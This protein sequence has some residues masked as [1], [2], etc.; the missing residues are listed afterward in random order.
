MGEAVV[1]LKKKAKIAILLGAVLVVLT[2][3]VVR[4]FTINGPSMSPT[5][6]FHDRVIS[7]QAAYDLRLPFTDTVLLPLSDPGRGDLVIY[8]DIPKNHVAAKRVVGLP[9]D[10][11]E[12]KENVLHVNGTP[13]DQVVLD[14]EGYEHLAAENDLGELVVEETLDGN[15]HLMTYTPQENKAASFGPVAVPPDE[16]FILGDNRDNSNDSRFVGFI[17]RDQIKG[18]IIYGAR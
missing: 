5:L 18:R 7:F 15:A 4:A 3:T 13:A 8:F 17:A 2:P 16:Y 11:I 12:L 1:K 6:L 9:G 10:T 14:R